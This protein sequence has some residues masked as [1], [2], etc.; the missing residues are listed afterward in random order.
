MDRTQL[1]QNQTGHVLCT[2]QDGWW[3]APPSEVRIEK[4]TSP[5]NQLGC[6]IPRALLCRNWGVYV[7][8]LVLACILACYF[9]ALQSLSLIFQL[10]SLITLARCCTAKVA[11]SVHQSS[12]F[13]PPFF[14]PCKTGSRDGRAE[15]THLEKTQGWTKVV[16]HFLRLCLILMLKKLSENNM[17]IVICPI[18]VKVCPIKLPSTDLQRVCC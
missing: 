14:F 2:G 13:C 12:I 4:S 15:G 6:I 7:L 8:Q 1:L 11:L 17:P 3:E 5:L 10:P 18:T 9:N 16:S